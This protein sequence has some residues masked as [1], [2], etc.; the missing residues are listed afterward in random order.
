[1]I[2]FRIAPLWGRALIIS[3][4][5]LL[6]VAALA[7][8]WAGYL[9]LTGNLHE[10]AP[11]GVY[12]SAQ[13]SPGQLRDILREKNIHTVINLR[14]SNPGD[15]WYDA[16]VAVARQAGAQHISLRMSAL[17][18][19][20]DALVGELVNIL[21]SAPKPLIIHCNAGADRTGLASAL[22]QL[23]LMHLPAA[24]ADKQLSFRYGHF[25]WLTSRSGAM[26]RTYWRIVDKF[27]APGQES[28]L[29]GET[30]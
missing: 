2:R 6:L 16:E 30:P 15:S 12:R 23:E 18:E 7:G 24:E 21:R 8:G 19:P 22:Y 29:A 4:S 26:D 13:L 27:A 14:G 28:K 9:N 25:P 11:G 3:L 20:D 10:I 1:M 5:T 17:R